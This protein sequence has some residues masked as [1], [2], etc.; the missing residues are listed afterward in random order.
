MCHAY[1]EEVM[2]AVAAGEGGPT[3]SEWKATS[4]GER[5]AVTVDT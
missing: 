4:L 1:L 5:A 3:S 2:R